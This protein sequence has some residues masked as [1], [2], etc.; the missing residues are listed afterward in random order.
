VNPSIGS[1]KSEIATPLG[2]AP[3]KIRSVNKSISQNV[4]YP[5][6]PSINAHSVAYD[7]Q[8]QLEKIRMAVSEKTVFGNWDS[9]E[10]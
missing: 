5:A 6:G 10:A 1:G 8:Q 7:S 3:P 9:D 4:T 2:R